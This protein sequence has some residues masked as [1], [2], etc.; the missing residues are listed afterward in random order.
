MGIDSVRIIGRRVGIIAKI[1]KIGLA[2]LE[3]VTEEAILAGFSNQNELEGKI[4]KFYH[5]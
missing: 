2:N 4:K 5:R 3:E 1:L